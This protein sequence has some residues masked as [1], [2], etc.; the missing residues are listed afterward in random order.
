MIKPL[1]TVIVVMK[2]VPGTQRIGEVLEIEKLEHYKVFRAQQIA[3][4]KM[5][6]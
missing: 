6:Q 2:H 1:R 4:R 5:N 3:K